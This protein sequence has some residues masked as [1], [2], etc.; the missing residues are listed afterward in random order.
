M[1]YT[2]KLA[3]DT[4]RDVALGNAWHLPTAIWILFL[5]LLGTAEAAIP[6]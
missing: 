5:V 1:G 4:Q 2:E 3:G 6:R